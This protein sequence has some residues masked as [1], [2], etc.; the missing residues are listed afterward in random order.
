MTR[1]VNVDM[2]TRVAKVETAFNRFFKKH[3]ELEYWRETFEY[4]AENNEDFF[5]DKTM[6]DGTVNTNWAYA[7][8]LD[9][10]DK[11][12]YMAVIERA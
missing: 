5:S 10:D 3:P 6:A 7:L 11:F 8:H 1:T 2:E 9:I 12:V 4:M